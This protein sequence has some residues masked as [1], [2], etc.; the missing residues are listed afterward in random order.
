MSSFFFIVSCRVERSLLCRV[1]LFIVLFIF[2][3][4]G[5]E[6]VRSIFFF[7]EDYGGREIGFRG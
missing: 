6:R 5:Y 1:F 7:I 3:F 2:L 4:W